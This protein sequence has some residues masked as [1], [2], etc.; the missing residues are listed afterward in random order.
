MFFAETVA[1]VPPHVCTHPLVPTFRARAGV[2]I[3]GPIL[4]AKAG[5]GQE[6]GREPVMTADLLCASWG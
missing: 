4:A 5:S 3:T 1:P 2:P 6:R